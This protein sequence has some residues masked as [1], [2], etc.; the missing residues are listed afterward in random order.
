[1]YKGDT[2]DG[3]RVPNFRPNDHVLGNGSV[4]AIIVL[5]SIPRPEGVPRLVLAAHKCNGKASGACGHWMKGWKLPSGLKLGPLIA[6]VATC[7]LGV[8]GWADLVGMPRVDGVDVEGRHASLAFPAT[9]LKESSVPRMFPPYTLE[10]V[11]AMDSVAPKVPNCVATPT[12]AL[13]PSPPRTPKTPT[14]TTHT[15]DGVMQCETPCGKASMTTRS[16]SRTLGVDLCNTSC[17]PRTRARL[18]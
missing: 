10:E 9:M 8:H 1:M 6:Q 16:H 17:R 4:K 13:I 2:E 12:C 14:L 7:Y 11:L 3:E 5:Y 15:R 18:K